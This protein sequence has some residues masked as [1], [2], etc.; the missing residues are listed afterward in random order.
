[1]V[2]LELKKAVTKQML[3]RAEEGAVS[4]TIAQ[5]IESSNLISGAY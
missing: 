4:L 1:V 5:K 2:E 3:I